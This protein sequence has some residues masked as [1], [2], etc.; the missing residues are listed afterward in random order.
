MKISKIEVFSICEKY[1]RPIPIGVGTHYLRKNLLVKITADNGL[2]GW[3]EGSPLIPAYS[4]EVRDQ[5]ID[6]IVKMVAPDILDERI[7]N[8]SDVIDLMDKVHR[9]KYYFMCTE[10]AVDIALF[11]L[12]GQSKKEPIF[13]LIREELGIENLNLNRLPPLPANFAVSRNATIKDDKINEM[14]KESEKY[15]D[16]GFQT[17]KIK[18]GIYKNSDIRAITTLHKY[19]K[20][21]FPDRTIYLFAD[22]NQSYTTVEEGLEIIKK[23]KAY[24]VCV[25]QPFHRNLSVLSKLLYEKMKK[26]ENTPLLITDE[27]SASIEE[28]ENILI[29]D[30]SGGALLKMVRSGGF[31][32]IIKLMKLLKKYPNFKLVPCSMT[33]TGIGTLANLHSAL[34]VYD[35]CDLKLGFGFD[36]PLQVIGDEY[37]KG[38]DT[39]LYKNKEK[40]LF[41]LDEKGVCIYNPEEIKGT[42]NGLGI[43][44]NHSYINKITETKTIIYQKNGII[45]KEEIPF[46]K[47]KDL[48]TKKIKTKLAKK[49]VILKYP[50]Y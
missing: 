10:A 7:A 3:G 20:N 46:K 39:I 14:I 41:T 4:G 9:N 38:K 16:R 25:E 23:I 12:V 19:L 13:N 43:S 17:I 45:I 34:V 50:R 42:G 35:Y 48:K 29:G 27:G 28:M 44:V 26:M 37:K 1:K 18:I 22:A 40:G 24:V 33:E 5:M 32:F 47:G 21:N 15:I 8:V 30:A 31:S 36:G 49:E 11:D 2:V 6:D